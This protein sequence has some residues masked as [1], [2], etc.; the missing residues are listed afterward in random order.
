E[1]EEIAELAL[2]MRRV[3]RE[4]PATARNRIAPF[5]FLA[6]P[7]TTAHEQKLCAEKYA[8]L[9]Y[10][11][12]VPLREKLGF[13]F[14]RKGNGKI[15]LGYI[16]ADFRE[17]PVS[18]LMVEVF[19]THDRSRFHVTAYSYT[20]DDGS[21]MRR[22]VEG[23]FDEFV[24]IGALS[25][26]EAARRIC[27]DGIDI[28]VDLTGYTRGNRS[29][30]LALRPAPVQ[31]TYIGFLG[32]MGAD[33][34]DYLIADPFLIRQGEEIHYTEKIAC[35]ESYQANDSKCLIGR[36][37]SRMECGLPEN[38]IVFCSF[39]QTFKITQDIF[40]VWMR[41]LREMPGSVFWLFSSNSLASQNLK[42]EA[43]IRGVSPERLVFAERVPLAQHLGRLKCAD[44][45]L[46]NLPYNAG[47]TASNALWAGLPVIT[48][49]GET[50]SSRMAGSLL[51][52]LGVP[53][54]ITDTLEH[55]HDLALELARDGEK[56]VRIRERID[57]NRDI[58]P[59]FDTE[60]FT[61]NLEHAFVEM[62]DAFWRKTATD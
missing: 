24:D 13:R 28:L 44:I 34:I 37:P 55:Y 9:S 35:L 10:R 56:L 49:T 32:T 26:E 15:R 48:C 61:R 47:T 52:A 40:D 21:A 57:K 11:H 38:G 25:F 31:V 2:E 62:H 60:R 8:K 4:E 27:G 17:H 36:T 18:Q 6:F 43:Q 58:M 3:V 46:D 45:F 54:L 50:F 5:A 7:G 33:F 59:L 30:I 19:E 41:L 53:E 23:A 20:S 22:R 29:G 42:R 51:T 16:S 14:E 39:N 1:W 12:L